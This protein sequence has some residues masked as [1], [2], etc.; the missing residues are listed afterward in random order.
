MLRLAVRGR[1]PLRHGPPVPYPGPSRTFLGPRTSPHTQGRRSGCNMGVHWGTR[2]AGGRSVRMCFACLAHL[3]HGLL[4]QRGQQHEV[5]VL[6]PHHVVL[7]VLGQH[8]VRELLVGHLRGM[9]FRT[10]PDKTSIHSALHTCLLLAHVHTDT[11]VLD[12]TTSAN[13]SLATCA[14]EG[15]GCTALPARTHVHTQRCT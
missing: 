2:A 12:R 8:H 10:R 11:D 4:E 13:F 3:R 14:E 15:S 1:F 6:H 9:G 7:A 5:V